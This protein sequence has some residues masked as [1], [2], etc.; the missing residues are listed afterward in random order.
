MS[1]EAVRDAIIETVRSPVHFTRTDF[2]L[3]VPAFVLDVPMNLAILERW[4]P[5]VEIVEAGSVRVDD[6][7]LR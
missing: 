7:A 2:R 6:E 3:Y 4:F 5:G 1:K